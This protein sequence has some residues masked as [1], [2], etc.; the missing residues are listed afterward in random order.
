M[1]V[2][3]S[4]QVG[5]HDDLT[6]AINVAFESGTFSLQDFGEKGIS[7]IHP[8]WLVRG[9]SNNVLG[10]S[11]AYHNA[12]G[13]NM[14]YAMGVDG[15]WNAILEGAQALVDGRADIVIVGGSDDLTAATDV[16]GAE[17]SEGAAFFILKPAASTMV[18]DRTVYESLARPFGLLGAATIPVGMALHEFGKQ[19]E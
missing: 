10:F 12:Q 2:G 18:L 11:S 3:A 15:G 14:S 1:Y 8:L 4:P 6:D 19:L 16:L 17:G 13:H 7:Q 9:L 5:R